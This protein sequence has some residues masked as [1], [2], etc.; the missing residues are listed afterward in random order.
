VRVRLHAGRVDAAVG[1]QHGGVLAG[2]L[3]AALAGR[4]WRA[5]LGFAAAWTVG[6]CLDVGA[7]HL[8]LVLAGLWAAWP[9]RANVFLL[10]V[11]NGA[12]SIAAIGR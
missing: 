7:G 2:M 11:A 10:G 8:G 9:L 4:R 12:F 1:L 5:R 3:L 6:G